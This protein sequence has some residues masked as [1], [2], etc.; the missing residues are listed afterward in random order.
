MKN[1]AG[2]PYVKFHDDRDN[3]PQRSSWGPYSNPFPGEDWETAM[4]F[5]WRDR[6]LVRYVVSHR[7]PLENGPEVYHALRKRTIPASKVLFV[8]AEECGRGSCT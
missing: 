8:P 1:Q 2:V 5:L 7:L 6:D 3:L 4:H